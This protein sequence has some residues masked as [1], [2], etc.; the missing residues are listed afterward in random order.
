ML[1]TILGFLLMNFAS[2]R[3]AAV[4]ELK[5]GYKMSQERHMDGG[6]RCAV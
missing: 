3:V 4:G 1:R 5:A 6:Y 2:S